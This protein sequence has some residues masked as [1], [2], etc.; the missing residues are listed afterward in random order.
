MLIGDIEVMRSDP[1]MQDL[2]T[3][4]IEP[5]YVEYCETQD[6]RHESGAR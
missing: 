5:K 3:E 6:L 1:K 2:E 4:T